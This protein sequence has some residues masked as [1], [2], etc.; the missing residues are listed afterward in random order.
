MTMSSFFKKKA[1]I[2]NTLTHKENYETNKVNIDLKNRFMLWFWM[3]PRDIPI[4]VGSGKRNNS[5]KNLKLSHGQF[6][7]IPKLTLP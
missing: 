1:N 4:P 3:K 6:A 5:V 7:S 2:S